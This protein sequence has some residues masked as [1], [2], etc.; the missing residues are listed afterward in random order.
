L[1]SSTSLDRVQS[2]HRLVFGDDSFFVIL[3]GALNVNGLIGTEYNGIAVCWENK[4]KVVL[5]DH[6][7]DH[8][9]AQAGESQQHE[10]A[11]ICVMNS[12]QFRTFINNHAGA[13]CKVLVAKPQPIIRP[14]LNYQAADFAPTKFNSAED[15]VLFRRALIFFLCNHCDRDRFTRRI[16]EGL[17]L[18]LG[19]IAH[20]NMGGFY[21]EWF[22][23]PAACVRFL[24][25]HMRYE[26]HGDWRDVAESFK[27]WLLSPQGQTVL[28]H[29]RKAAL[30]TSNEKEV[31]HAEK[32]T[33]LGP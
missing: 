12:T 9:R 30:G 29:Y 24:E 22:R 27:Q 25:H 15:K 2:I 13:Q 32:E 5:M 26:V 23:D 1:T 33:T 7:R 14:K 6:Y 21:D 16:Y 31:A 11:R 18:H 17:H 10:Y 4:G 3:Y 19:H 28:A 20:Y 8:P